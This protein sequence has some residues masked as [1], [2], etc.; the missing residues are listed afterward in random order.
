M[1]ITILPRTGDS[2]GVAAAQ[3]Q[4]QVLIED[5]R[6]VIAIVYGEGPEIER[7][8]EIAVGRATIP[9]IPPD[10]RRVVWCPDE[11]ILSSEQKKKYFRKNKVVVFV[12]LA[13]EIAEALDIDEGR[14]GLSV[15]L[16]F[17]KAA[18]QSTDGAE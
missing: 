6:T 8:I 16:G 5:V 1:A 12:G 14:S 9:T 2:G 10:L 3:A 17:Q 15:E 11:T 18:A 7:V 4:L 13:D